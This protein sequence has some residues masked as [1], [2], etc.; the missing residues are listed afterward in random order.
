MLPKDSEILD[1]LNRHLRALSQTDPKRFLI[2]SLYMYKRLTNF[3]L[4]EIAN[5]ADLF[6]SASG[7]FSYTGISLGLSRKILNSAKDKINRNEDKS[8]LIFDTFEVIHSCLA[9]D[10]T[11]L[12]EYDDHLV[13]ENLRMGEI[14]YSATYVI[15][16]ALI[17]I[18]QGRFAEAQRQVDKLLEIGDLY[19]HDNTMGMYYAQI[20]RIHTEY[21][22]FHNALQAIEQGTAYT[23][24]VD[25]RL[26][27]SSLQMNKARVEMRMGSFE[28]A[29]RT[30]LRENKNSSRFARI[31]LYYADFLTLLFLLELH[32]MEDGIRNGD[33]SKVTSHRKKVKKTGKRMM[34]A[35]KKAVY[36]LPEALRLI[37]I[38]YWLTGNQGRA[39]AW[40]KRSIKEGVRL[41]ARLELSRTYMEV[42]KRL[43]EPMSKYRE[44]NGLGA[45]DY[46]NKSR[47]MFEDMGLQWD[48]DELEKVCAPN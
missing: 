26:W 27:Y 32:G 43:M 39:F 48:L 6:T 35:A 10:W 25:S 15:W 33:P 1:L 36:H 5:S 24:R 46:L 3:T 23:Y 4:T 41:G 18:P 13:D 19:E 2:E 37:G 8:A 16:H 42:G 29:E 9:R 11:E 31:K 12:R 34:N 44:L 20:A 45:E 21:G 7:A 38:Y 40:F 47:I 14:F 28:E 30:P 22:R 17:S